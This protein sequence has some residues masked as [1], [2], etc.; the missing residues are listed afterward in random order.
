VAEVRP[1][2]DRILP[3]SPDKSRLEPF[4]RDVAG[5]LA[6]VRFPPAPGPSELTLPV[7][8]YG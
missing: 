1:L 3:L 6:D 4:K 5:L 8:V 2:C 7:L